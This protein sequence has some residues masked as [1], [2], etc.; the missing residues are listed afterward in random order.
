MGALNPEKGGLLRKA[1]LAVAVV[2]AVL[3][4]DP[5]ATGGLAAL[6]R[7]IGPEALR[8]N[9]FCIPSSHFTAISFL[10]FPLELER[11]RRG[12]NRKFPFFLN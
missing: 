1:K 2:V 8:L 6:Q 11:E 10:F 5:K 7:R 12:K 9:S 4:L 3:N